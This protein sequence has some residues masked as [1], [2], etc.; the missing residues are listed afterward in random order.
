MVLSE[1]KRKTLRKHIFLPFQNNLDLLVHE[2]HLDPGAATLVLS[3]AS[4]LMACHPQPTV[5]SEVTTHFL[6]PASFLSCLSYFLCGLGALGH[7]LVIFVIS[8]FGS[9]PPS[10]HL[11]LRPLRRILKKQ[12]LSF[13]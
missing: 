4:P 5:G 11:F 3:E 2:A 10:D 1:G 8:T 6:L 7:Y 12:Q 13:L 9:P